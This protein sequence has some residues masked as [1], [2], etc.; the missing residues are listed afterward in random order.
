MIRS[1][2]SDRSEYSDLMRVISSSVMFS[3]TACRSGEDTRSERDEDSS[4]RKDDSEDG[5]DLT[6]INVNDRQGFTKIRSVHKL[7]F[8]TNCTVLLLTRTI[9]GQLFFGYRTN[10]GVWALINTTLEVSLSVE[11]RTLV[12]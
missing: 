8:L 7:A 10:V 11:L 5:N 3:A 6:C 2:R 4:F 12:Q 9:L 1:N